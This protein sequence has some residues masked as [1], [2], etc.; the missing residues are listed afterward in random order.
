MMPAELYDGLRLHYFNSFV[1]PKIPKG[2]NVEATWAEFKKLTERPSI[3]SAEG[4]IKLHGQIAAASAGDALLSPLKDLH[5][6]F[7]KAFDQVQARELDLIR[8]GAR[9]GVNT[10]PAQ[11][12]GSFAGQAVDF[13][14]L[15][16]VM[17]PA[18]AGIAA[19]MMTSAKGVELAS[20][21]LRGGLAFGTYDA[22]SADQGNRLM[23]G[24]K[25]F[26]GGAAFDPLP[27]GFDVPR[28]RKG[29]GGHRLKQRIRST[30][31]LAR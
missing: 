22:L 9:E 30:V 26:A 20:R 7:K 5:P 11:V 31:M 13:S 4:K 3:L 14:I 27:N 17:G 19:E 28:D 8:M 1:S 24:L 18:A 16:E 10:K 15:S 21:V 25:G 2:K 6:D 12:L 29:P 23:S